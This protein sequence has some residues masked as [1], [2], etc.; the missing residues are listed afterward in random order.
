ML[1][2]AVPVLLL[3]AR[4]AF[5]PTT[6]ARLLMAGRF[7]AIGAGAVL[8]SFRDSGPAFQVVGSVLLG[9]SAWPVP[10]TRTTA[11]PAV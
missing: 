11:S 6:R 9:L 2:G 3:I 4:V 7:L 8:I 1:M 5:G 10:A